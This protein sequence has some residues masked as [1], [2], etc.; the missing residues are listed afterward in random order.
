MAQR[1]GPP[2][3]GAGAHPDLGVHSQKFRVGTSPLQGLNEGALAEACPPPPSADSVLDVISEG[4]T[5]VA[6]EFMANACVCMCVPS[7]K[8]HFL[9]I[10]DLG[11][12]LYLPL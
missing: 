7:L 1:S 2:S 8:K 12:V 6:I 5:T 10:L 11:T 9:R 3:S 4:K